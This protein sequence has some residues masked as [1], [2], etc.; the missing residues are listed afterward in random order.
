MSDMPRL[1]VHDDSNA[2]SVRGP[3]IVGESCDL[4]F[5]KGVQGY[6]RNVIGQRI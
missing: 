5:A 2:R 1:S 4:P 6:L 3:A